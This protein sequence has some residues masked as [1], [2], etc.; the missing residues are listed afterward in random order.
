MVV[1][2]EH[3]RAVESSRAWWLWTVSW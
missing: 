1:W 2:Q 3:L